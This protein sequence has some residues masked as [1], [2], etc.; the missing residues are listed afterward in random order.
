MVQAVHPKKREISRTLDKL[1]KE[2]K[3][4]VDKSAE[5][6][7][8][9]REAA[10]QELFNKALEDAEAKLREMENSVASD[11]IGND[12][13]G[14]KDLLKKHQVGIFYLMFFRKELVLCYV[15]RAYVLGSS[16]YSVGI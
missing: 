8:K 12:L 15:C 7:K 14:V 6:G 5:K 9:L 16:G 11:D 4:L 1:N 13:R 2:W 10:Q 3:D